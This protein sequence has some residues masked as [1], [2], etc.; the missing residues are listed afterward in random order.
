[1]VTDLELTQRQWQLVNAVKSRSSSVD[2]QLALL[3]SQARSVAAS[4]K[5]IELARQ[6]LVRDHVRQ[7]SG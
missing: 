7:C 3:I 5:D 1:V 6:H 2:E 4:S